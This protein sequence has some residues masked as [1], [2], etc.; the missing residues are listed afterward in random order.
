MAVSRGDK[1]GRRLV[2][3]GFS[4]R[5]LGISVRCSSALPTRQLDNEPGIQ[6]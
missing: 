1:D 3:E 4:Y 6:Q 2:D 5:H